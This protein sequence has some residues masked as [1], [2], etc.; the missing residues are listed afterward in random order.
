[1]GGKQCDR[2]LI[3]LYSWKQSFVTHLLKRAVDLSVCV[4]VHVCLALSRGLE[5]KDTMSSNYWSDWCHSLPYIMLGWNMTVDT[6]FPRYR[7]KTVHNDILLKSS[8]EYQNSSL[9]ENVSCS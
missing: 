2:C 5:E 4:C 1:M 9:K 3:F 7:E 6:P 8:L